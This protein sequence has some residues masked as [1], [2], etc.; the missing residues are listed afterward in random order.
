MMDLI[1]PYIETILIVLLLCF[2]G[3]FLFCRIKKVSVINV[4]RLNNDMT[5]LNNELKT[6]EK[7]FI[8]QAKNFERDIQNTV[9]LAVSENKAV[10][11]DNLEQVKDKF[12][13]NK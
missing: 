4:G 8:S 3:F 7:N 13:K 12:N 9:N 11:D 5:G 1:S 10:I 2:V 6:M